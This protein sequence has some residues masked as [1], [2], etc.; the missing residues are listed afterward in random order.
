VAAPVLMTALPASHLIKQAMACCHSA[1]NIE[2]AH[3]TRHDTHGTTRH[4]HVAHGTTRH[5]WHRINPIGLHIYQ[6]KD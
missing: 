5:T 4:T 1:T 6:A 3:D 2:G